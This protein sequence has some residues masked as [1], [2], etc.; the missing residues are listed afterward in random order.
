MPSR[1]RLF[2]TAWIRCRNVGKI[3]II[4]KAGTRREGYALVE[5]DQHLI[6][7]SFDRLPQN[8]FRCS[9]GVDIGSIEHIETGLQADIHESR[10]RSE[11]S[12]CPHALKK[13]PLPPNIAR[14]Q[15]SQY[16]H[17]PGPIGPAFYIPSV[18]APPFQPCTGM[19]EGFVLVPT[20][21]RC[22]YR[23]DDGKPEAYR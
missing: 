5:G 8:L 22:R 10:Q 20:T 23:C 6:A 14:P 1:F 7:P 15:G 11:T 16:R 19:L 2:S 4:L 9:S 18:S 21:N 17:F 12:V 3:S 13:S